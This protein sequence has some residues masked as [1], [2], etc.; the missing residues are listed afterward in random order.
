MIQIHLRFLIDQLPT[1]LGGRGMDIFHLKFWGASTGGF[2][3]SWLRVHSRSVCFR[4][5]MLYHNQ[6]THFPHL[7]YQKKKEYNRL[8]TTESLH[9]SHGTCPNE[10]TLFL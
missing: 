1:K 6:S 8:Q 3:S 4:V 5:A 9:T 7:L 10:A 2:S